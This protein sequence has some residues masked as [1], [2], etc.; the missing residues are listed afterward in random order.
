MTY[1]SFFNYLKHSIKRVVSIRCKSIRTKITQIKTRM[2][3]TFFL[4]FC[5]LFISNSD[6]RSRLG[7]HF[8]YSRNGSIYVMLFFYIF[9]S[10]M[11]VSENLFQFKSSKVRQLMVMIFALMQLKKQRFLRNWQKFCAG[12]INMEENWFNK[13]AVSF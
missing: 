2:K 7:I 11:N 12:V 1:I 10:Y 3:F 5:M 13:I 4:I 8:Y 9:H 6:A